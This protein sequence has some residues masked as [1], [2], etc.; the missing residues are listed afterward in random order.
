MFQAT[1]K[2]TPLNQAMN[3]V[4]LIY[5]SIVHDVRKTHKNA[6]MAL[7]LAMLQAFLFVIS[8]YFMFTVLGLK[9]SKIRG[10]FLLFIMSG[11]FLFLTHIK[12]MGAVFKSEGPT[13]AMM[14]HAPL[15]TLIT[16]SAAALGSLYIQ[17]L[18]AALLLFLYHAIIT[19]I[20]IHDPIG[21]IGM[22]LLAWFTG[23]SIGI[24][25][26]SLKTWFPNFTTIVQS[27]YS[28]A[29]M[30][31]SGKM[32]VANATPGYILAMFDWN[33]LFHCIDQAR[34]YIFKDYFPHNSSISYPIYVALGLLVIGMMVEFF[35]RKSASVS[36]FATR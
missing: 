21:T 4:E 6:V 19:P 15:N 10:D 27:L 26:L 13:S 7:L 8:F 28:R 23:V 36:W 31:A 34:G 29:N 5:H 1:P 30:I 12:A 16:I 3:M 35:T 18:S 20:S 14:K 25:L 11:V 17:T 24:I 33:P 2:R 32:I 9:S 22:F